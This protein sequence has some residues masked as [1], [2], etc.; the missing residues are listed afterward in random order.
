MTERLAWRACRVGLLA[1]CVLVSGP[2]AVL[3]HALPGSVLLLQPQEAGLQLTIQFPLEDL[4]IAA[5]ELAALEEAT[6]EG[7]LRLETAELFN[8][9]TQRHLSLTEDDTTLPLT[10]AEVRLQSTYHEHLGHFMLVISQ[11]DV[12]N[13]TSEP[14]S[15]VLNYDAV[16]HEVRNHRAT[17]QWLAQDGALRQVAEFGLS[18][19]EDGIL[20][21]SFK[22]AS[23]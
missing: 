9:Y 17:V 14:S 3:A 13:V 6:S 20:L 1:L 16:M 11:W 22:M 23:D 10:L 15:L 21:D 7:P 18:R 12:A 19:T 5:P 8:Q 4:L 2:G